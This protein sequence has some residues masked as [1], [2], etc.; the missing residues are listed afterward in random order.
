MTKAWNYIQ[1]KHYQ[2]A[3]EECSRAFRETGSVSHLYNRGIA[4]L[5]SKNYSA[6]LEDH[7]NI[8]DHTEAKFLASSHYL[9]LGICYWYLDDPDQAVVSFQQSLSTPY[10]DASGGVQAPAILLYV[11][12]RLHDDK[13]RHESLQILK[14]YWRNHQRRQKRREKRGG[15]RTYHDFVYQG[16]FGWPGPIVPLLLKKIDKEYFLDILDRSA[17][18]STLKSRHECQAQ[19]YLATLA[20]L[21]GN[22][23][24]F[25]KAMK[26]CAKSKHGVLEEE[27]YLALWEVE[28]N[29]P[30]PAFALE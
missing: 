17:K 15:R 30:E 12:E 27:Y 26:S 7:Q 18:N 19:F 10:T 24:G 20:L 28:N 9:R 21:D 3:I 6:A 5:L 8:I 14:K 22:F 23:E 29:F 16:L 11:A 13:I 25:R 1:S 4:Y 2:L